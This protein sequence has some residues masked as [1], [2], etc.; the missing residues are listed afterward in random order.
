[1]SILCS[2]FAFTTLSTTGLGDLTPQNNSEYI[3]M[4]FIF[5]FGVLVFSMVSERF[6]DTLIEIQ[7]LQP[8][9]EHSE[10][11]HK[12]LNLMKQFNYGK[13]VTY[14]KQFIQFF[15]YKWQNDKNIM[16][17]DSIGQEIL[18][19][20]PS[21]VQAQIYKKFLYQKFLT[22]FGRIFYFKIQESENHF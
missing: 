22:Q 5:L 7:N 12:F 19:Q 15:Q 8:E 2:Y 9:N 3:L 4:I 18:N 10:D 17:E 6:G 14:D 11:L 13:N 1:M 20:L 16:V 21:H